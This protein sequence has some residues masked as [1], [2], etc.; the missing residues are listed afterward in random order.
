MHLKALQRIKIVRKYFKTW[1]SLIVC[2]R[3]RFSEKLFLF[4]KVQKSVQIGFFEFIENL[5]N[6]FFLNLF[7]NESL[8]CL[9]LSWA[10]PIFGKSHTWYGPKCSRPIRL[11]DFQIN[12][13]SSTKCW[14]SLI[15]LCWYNFMEIK[16]LKMAVSQEFIDWLNWFFACQGFQVWKFCGIDCY[17][18]RVVS[19]NRQVP[20]GYNFELWRIIFS[21]KCMDDIGR[22]F[23]L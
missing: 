13:I 4:Q 18:Y 17:R 1:Q 9:L 19:T 15:F 21:Y 11:Q 8:H 7:Y 10:S 5:F 16:I 22:G 12:N 14:N 2:D 6:V 3:A 20:K 23:L